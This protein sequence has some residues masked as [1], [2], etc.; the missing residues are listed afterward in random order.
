MTRFLN[1]QYNIRSVKEGKSIAKNKNSIIVK[2]ALKGSILLKFL[3][4]IIIKKSN[5]RIVP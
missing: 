2:N 1:I 4:I 5:V 3:I